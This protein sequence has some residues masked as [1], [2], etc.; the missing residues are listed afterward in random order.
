MATFE[1]TGILF[2]GMESACVTGARVFPSTISEIALHRA[3]RDCSNACVLLLPLFH[4]KILRCRK[5][6]SERGLWTPRQTRTFSGSSMMLSGPGRRG[7]MTSFSKRLTVTSSNALLCSLLECGFRCH[8]SWLPAFA[9]TIR[10]AQALAKQ[11]F[12][13]GSHGKIGDTRAAIRMNQRAANALLNTVEG[14]RGSA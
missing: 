7:S 3:N 6:F 4:A 8:W 9:P 5:F 13:G 11:A 14:R 2:V 12:C 10:Q 1:K